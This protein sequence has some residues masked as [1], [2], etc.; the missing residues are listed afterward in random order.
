MANSSPGSDEG[1]RLGCLQFIPRLGYTVDHHGHQGLV[2]IL[3]N[4]F[5]GEVER[6]GFGAICNHCFICLPYRALYQHI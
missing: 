2:T 5:T 1:I 4:R 6:L 3:P